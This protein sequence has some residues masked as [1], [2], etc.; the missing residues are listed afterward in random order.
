MAAFISYDETTKLPEPGALETDTLDFKGKM[1]R[2]DEKPDYPEL[3]KDIA[4]FA[5]AHGGVILVGAY[6]DKPNGRLGVI[7]GLASDADVK[8]VRDAYSKAAT[9]F[10]SPSPVTDSKVIPHSSGKV[11]AVN[12][13]PFPGQAVGVREEGY[14][15]WAF[16][17]RSHIE[18]KYLMPEQL[19]MLMIPELRSTTAPDSSHAEHACIS[20]SSF[21]RWQ[22]GHRGSQMA[23][24]RASA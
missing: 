7:K 2:R 5:N 13:W 20:G 11:I 19:P 21:S 8:E 4:A 10:C 22:V 14:E 17:W 24:V 6:E 18:T 16:P 23:I 12:V 3:A 1:D 9:E 15:R